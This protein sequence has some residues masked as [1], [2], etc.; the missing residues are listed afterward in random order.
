MP[1]TLASSRDNIKIHYTLDGSDPSIN[2]QLYSE[3]LVLDRTTIVKARIFRDGKP[4]SPVSEGMF[5]LVKP[6]PAIVMAKATPG[7]AF[8]YYQGKWDSLP[9]FSK[10]VPVKT[11]VAEDISVDPQLKEE[12]FAYRFN[13]AIS[14]PEDGV[15]SF[16][17]DSDDGSI[18]WID[19]KKV[20]DNDGLHSLLRKE[21]PVPLKKGLH[22]ITVGYFENSGGNELHVYYSTGDEKPQVIPQS[23][24]FH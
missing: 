21:G 6:W 4:V 1:V 14:I 7:V 10:L 2:S 3:P 17:T 16:Y 22:A 5:T 18:L 13:G 11:G 24:L 15:Y 20:V 23:W 8:E 19:G 12:E 9:D